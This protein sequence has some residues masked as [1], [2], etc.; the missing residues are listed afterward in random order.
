MGTYAGTIFG[1][2]ALNR[3]F[4]KELIREIQKAAV[5][6]QEKSQEPQVFQNAEEEKE[7]VIKKQ[8]RI[9]AE[10]EKKESERR[11]VFEQKRLS[12]RERA[13]GYVTNAKKKI[14]RLFNRLFAAFTPVQQP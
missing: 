11:V 3:V 4:L 5:E 12:W 2:E 8:L 13:E 9:I 6:Q 7:A 10:A 14:S 1:S